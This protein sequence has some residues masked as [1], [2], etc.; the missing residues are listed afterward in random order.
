V[1]GSAPVTNLAW[2]I[3]DKDGYTVLERSADNESMYRYLNSR[4]Y[5]AHINAWYEGRYHQI[6][7]EVHIDC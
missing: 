2:V 7:E 4:R 1:T 3:T 6:S 5:S